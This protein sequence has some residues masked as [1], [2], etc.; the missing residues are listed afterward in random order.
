MIDWLAS[1]GLLETLLMYGRQ[2][3]VLSLA[4]FLNETK[5]TMNF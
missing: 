2:N 5:V 1:Y 4:I 3:N